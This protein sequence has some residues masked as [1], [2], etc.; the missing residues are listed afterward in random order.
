MRYFVIFATLFSFASLG[1][2]EK[3]NDQY[4]A[5][6]GN[7]DAPVKITEYYSFSCPH[8][9]SLFREDFRKI[10][11]EYIKD[12]EVYWEFHPV[13]LDMA[14]VQ[15]MA[16]MERLSPRERCLFVEVL[17]EECDPSE[18]NL[19]AKLMM[20]AMEIFQKPI[21]DLDKEEFLTN[22]KA[23][24]DAFN[25]VKQDDHVEAVPT[26][27]INGKFYPDEVPDYT[28]ISTSVSKNKG[29]IN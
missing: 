10:Q 22:A 15:A 23:F 5:S 24:Q 21:E 27:S 18:A 29:D 13:P 28:F 9:V 19:T 7:P 25:F 12:G 17:L 16:C 1:A 26:V 20:K 2:F 14:T 8:C 3:L 11:E 4:I 6:Y